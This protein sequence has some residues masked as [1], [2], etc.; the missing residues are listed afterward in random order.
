MVSSFICKGRTEILQLYFTLAI[1][2]ANTSLTGSDVAFPAFPAVALDLFFR[3][4]LGTF[5]VGG[6]SFWTSSGNL[7]VAG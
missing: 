3:G 2:S 6:N 4:V 5:K 7:G 1:L